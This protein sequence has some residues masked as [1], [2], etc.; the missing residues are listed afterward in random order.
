M[1]RIVVYDLDNVAVGEF[2]AECNRGWVLLGNT[3][4]SDGAQTTVTIPKDVARQT[5]LQLGRVVMVERPPLPAWVGVIDTPWKATLPV[6]LTLYNAE[7]LLSL[8]DVERSVA[9][10]STVPVIVEQMINLANEQENLYIKMG[11]ATSTQEQF[12]RVIEQSNIWDQMLDF[13]QES[14]HEMILR[15]EIVSNRLWLAADVGVALGVDTNYQLHDG[16]GGNIS[17]RD[18]VVNE[19]IVN[20]VKAVSGNSTEEAQLETD[21]LEDQDSQAIYRTRSEMLNY[22]NVTQASTLTQY[23]QAYL[24]VSSAPYVDFTVEVRNVADAFSN[25][26]LGNRCFLRSSSVYLPGGVNGWSGTVRILSMAVDETK[27]TVLTKLRGL[28]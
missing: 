9:M 6:E 15:P 25:M 10:N 2:K 13:L 23:A 14:G 4:V 3:G 11:T 21:V 26:R 5:W 20:R 8:R 1:S 18:A 16:R 17:V 22:R 27:D 12:A 19:K 24:D 7:Y 28:L